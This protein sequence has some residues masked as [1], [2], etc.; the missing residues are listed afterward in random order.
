M[1]PTS[2]EFVLTMPGDAR[3]VGAVRLLAA[4]AAGYAQLTPQAGEGLADHVE[5]VTEAAIDS[6]NSQN[7]PIELRF[8]GDQGTVNVRISWEAAGAARQ[9]RS[10]PADGVSV[11]WSAS[12]SRHTCHIRQRIPA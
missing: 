11:N 9:P 12:G 8:S 7:T 2:F 3:L 1:T 4:Q 10:S 5:R 6:T